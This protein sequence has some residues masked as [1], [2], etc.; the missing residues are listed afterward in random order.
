[1]KPCIQIL[2]EHMQIH[3]WAVNLFFCPQQVGCLLAERVQDHFKKI[4]RGL[5]IGGTHALLSWTGYPQS[6]SSTH[7]TLMVQTHATLMALQVQR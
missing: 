5:C 4:K 6:T 7:A 2:A 3:R 1:M